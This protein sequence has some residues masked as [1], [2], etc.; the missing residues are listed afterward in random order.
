MSCVMFANISAFDVL[1]LLM[2]FI[3]FVKLT[4]DATER[5]TMQKMSKVADVDERINILLQLRSP[6]LPVPIF[7]F[8]LS[9]FQIIDPL[10]VVGFSF[11]GT[12]NNIYGD[13]ISLML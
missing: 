6:P 12:S 7:I 2:A 11:R 10:G 4:I 1:Y 3:D 5:P 9:S 13:F 8:A